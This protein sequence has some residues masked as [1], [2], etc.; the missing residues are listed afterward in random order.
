MTKALCSDWNLGIHNEESRKQFAA[1]LRNMA[2]DPCLK[3]LKTL[4]KRQADMSGTR[5]TSLKTYDKPG[6]EGMLAHQNGALHMAQYVLD[7]L[8]FVVDEDYNG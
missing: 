2:G 8:E 4:M 3:K 1:K 5:M 6:W 7:L